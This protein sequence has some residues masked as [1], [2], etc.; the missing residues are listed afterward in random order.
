MRMQLVLLLGGFLSAAALPQVYAAGGGCFLWMDDG[1]CSEF[2]TGVADAATCEGLRAS[3]GYT[4]CKFVDPN[5]PNLPNP[6]FASEGLAQNPNLPVVYADDP[7]DPNV[8]IRWRYVM[9]VYC[10]AGDP[11][12]EVH[13]LLRCW[14]DDT[15]H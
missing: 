5:D 9:L 10:E 15:H 11:C 13:R 4:K 2:R 8:T 7:N 1:S 3:L 12:K 6:V 14:R